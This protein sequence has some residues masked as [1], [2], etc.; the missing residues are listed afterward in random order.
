MAVIIMK[1][2]KKIF[3]IASI[4]IMIAIGYFLNL[5]FGNPISKRVAERE[6]I[7]Y[8]E[9]KYNKDF[10][11]YSSSYNFL[12]PDY[13]IKMGPN[14]DQEAVFVTSRYELT[15]FDAYGAYLATKELES[16][17]L[18]IIGSEYPEFKIT[19]TAYENHNIEDTFDE[20]DFFNSNPKIRLEKNYF[21][22]EVTWVDNGLSN[23]ETIKLM[24]DIALKINNELKGTPKQL[25]WE[26][27]VKKNNRSKVIITRYY[28]NGKALL[29]N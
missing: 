13:N 8:F 1:L 6:V 12:I 4:A 25:S 29:K 16:K 21:L 27:Y 9:D 14:D 5:F 15:R 10:T 11:V 20:F 24:D 17:M 28:I 19:V 26:F 18:K 7:T 23:D 2:K 3:I 22:A